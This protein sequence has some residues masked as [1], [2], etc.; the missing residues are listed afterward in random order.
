MHNIPPGSKHYMYQ[1]VS[2]NTSAFC[3][4]CLDSYLLAVWTILDSHLPAIWLGPLLFTFDFRHIQIGHFLLP[5]RYLKE[6]LKLCTSAVHA[7]ANSSIHLT[8]DP[9]GKVVDVFLKKYSIS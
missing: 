7:N 9:D 4:L 2:I 3:S 8:G 1:K 6:K 5:F